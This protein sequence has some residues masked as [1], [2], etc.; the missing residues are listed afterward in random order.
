MNPIGYG[1]D[2]GTTNSAVSIAYDDRVEVV[3]IE[4]PTGLPTMLPSITYL[5]RDGNRLAGM[6]AAETYMVT[7]AQRHR[8]SA[9]AL[10]EIY[11]GTAE[12]DCR[13]YRRGGGCLDSRLLAGLKFDLADTRFPGTNSWA[14]DFPI[15]DL[16]A[17]VL[18]RLKRHADRQSGA[19]VR[20]AVLGCP[21][22]FPGSEG[23]DYPRRQRLAQQ[24]LGEAATAAGFEEIQLLWEPQAAAM[25]EDADE[26]T[27]LAL[28]FGGG[29]FDAAILEFR[30][31]DAE[32]TALQGAAIGGE[33]LDAMLFRH[34]VAPA[35]GLGATFAGQSGARLGM[36]RWMQS[37][38]ESLSGLKHLVGEPD[39]AVWLH[40]HR[41]RAGG[42]VLD[43]LDHLLYGGYAYAFYKAIEQAKMD[44]SVREETRIT[45]RR[46]D[47]Q[48]DIPLTRDEFDGLVQ[49]Y[50][51]Q[52]DACIERTLAQARKKRPD[53]TYVVSTGGSSRI[54][55]YRSML[56]AGFG[57]DHVV[58]RDPFNT[59][60][61]GLGYEA[62]G[63]WG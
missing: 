52:V 6:Q 59:V 32:V 20:R 44:L 28:D 2:F 22:A 48:I 17:I 23:S 35:V 46:P 24:R 50:L 57:A 30:E 12:T 8:C 10:V 11:E 31:E 16:V 60:V 40:E 62:Q 5:H 21:L 41:S 26:G 14:R 39:V 1:I 4:P 25:V 34:K 51:D 7:G 45:F 61:T 47:L 56:D 38:F 58:D 43:V 53:I 13:Q 29:T 42:E 9:C 27:V 37:R 55:A 19:D 36:P 33:L 54:P 15:A 18:R 3:P 63:R 49:P